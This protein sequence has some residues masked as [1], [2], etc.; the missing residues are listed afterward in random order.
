M[1]VILVCSVSAEHTFGVFE[2]T[3]QP[4]AVTGLSASRYRG[5]I[6]SFASLTP[7]N[8]KDT[9]DD[10]QVKRSLAP[11]PTKLLQLLL[12]ADRSVQ[13]GLHAPRQFPDPVG[14]AEKILQ[15]TG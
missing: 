3:S 6:D 8:E 7:H 2:V 14:V 11:P 15:Q 1:R 9:E 5:P 10:D 13:R 4:I 12:P